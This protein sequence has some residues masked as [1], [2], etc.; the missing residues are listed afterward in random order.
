MVDY[1]RS[2]GVLGFRHTKEGARPAARVDL[3]G[4]GE[5]P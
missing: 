3:G 2:L 5:L 1:E 4:G